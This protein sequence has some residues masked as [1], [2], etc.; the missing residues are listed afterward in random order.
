M[1]FQQT[2]IS[3]DRQ[4]SIKIW[5][6]GCSHTQR[7]ITMDGENNIAIAIAQLSERELEFDFSFNTGDFDSGQEPPTLGI[8]NTEAGETIVTTLDSLSDI[9]LTPSKLYRI[10]G[11]HDAGDANMDWFLRYLDPLGDN[12]AYSHVDPAIRPH[13]I[14]LMGTGT[15]HSYY[16]IVGKNLFLFISD[17][18]ELPYPYG[19]GG[20]VV[21]GG[22]PS[23]AITLE[24]WEWMQEVILNNKDKNIFV[25]THQNPR[26]TTIGT[27]DN[28]G[29]IGIETNDHLHGPSGIAELSGSLGSIY[30]EI[31]ETADSPT[32]AFLDF[33]DANPDHTVVSWMATHSHAY[34]NEV[35]NGRGQRFDTHGVVFL[36]IGHLIMNHNPGA[37]GR[38]IVERMS[39]VLEISSKNLNV[40]H[41]NHDTLGGESIGFYEPLEYNIPLKV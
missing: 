30:D 5:A 13:P 23:G 22:H 3:Q 34:L 18:N 36:N 24:T 40:K 11:N 1:A 31:T 8:S 12:T 7:D 26:N 35:L 27:G 32:S 28:D 20:S 19:R 14:T 33:L 29:I 25:V 15:W 10:A 4:D 6:W 37:S 17:R 16:I 39:K 9:G 21:E 41:F 38:I 2:Y